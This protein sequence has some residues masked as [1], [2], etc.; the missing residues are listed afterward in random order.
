M[1]QFARRTA[2]LA[3]ATFTQ[4]LDS[5]TKPPTEGAEFSCPMTDYPCIMHCKAIGYRGGYCG[6]FLNL[7]CRCH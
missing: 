2:T 7:S 4:A 1:K 3:D 5:E 6:G